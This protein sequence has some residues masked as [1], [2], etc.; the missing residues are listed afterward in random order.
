MPD[1]FL[2]EGLGFGVAVQD[3]AL[4]ALLVVE[5]DLHREARAARPPRDR[6]ESRP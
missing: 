6:A 2:E 5:D 1:D 3:R 4:A